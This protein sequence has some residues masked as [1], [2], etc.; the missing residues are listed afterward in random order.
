MIN[1]LYLPELREMLAEHSESEL[2]E[3]CVALH[4]AR[5]AE[6]MEGL[7]ASEAWEVLKYAEPRLREQIFTFFPHDK[8]IEIFESQDRKEVAELIVELAADDR[9]DLLQDVR[10]EVVD[11]LL[12][13]LPAE[14]RRNILRL[15]SYPEGTAGA[16]M[17]TEAAKLS[18][19]LT[20]KEALDELSHQAEELE[21]IYYLYIVDD[22]DH[23]RGLVTARKLVSAIGKPNTR[24][25]E[26]MVTDLITAYVHEDQEE[27]ARR[28]AHYNLAAIPVV[29]KER[30]MLGI[31]THDDVID[32][33]REEAIEDVQKIAGV[34]PLEES[35]LTIPIFKLSRKRGT[36]LTVLF[37][38]GI[39]TALALQHYNNKLSTWGWLAW[40]LPLVIST[41]GNSGSQTAT[42]IIAA[43]TAGDVTVKDWFRIVKR[44]LIMGVTLGGFL[45][46]I[47]FVAAYFMLLHSTQPAGSP[48][49]N[50]SGAF[51]LP[52]TLVL[53][54]TCGTLVGSL[55]PLLFRRMGLD[56][57][58]MSNPFVAGIIDIVGILVYIN[59]AIMFM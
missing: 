8:Q 54:V 11:E 57:A 1:T 26:L 55:M 17:T 46:L 38:G 33:V 18:E 44:E 50:L 40:F 3:F 27:V 31:I 32:V 25:K 9:V 5:T 48:A 22:T 19:S 23:L 51:V 39:G 47:G 20:V 10:T 7:T 14:E 56:P 2:R 28:V 13:L 29:D 12:P 58:L 35:Y 4:P 52:I 15:R 42:L 59:I 41:G 43:L 37:V 53:V 6:F 36:W 24:L 16:K 45:G 30:R 34:Q 49:P 21:T